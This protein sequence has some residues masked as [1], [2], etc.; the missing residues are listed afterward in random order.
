MK[1][2]YRIYDYVTDENIGL[3]LITLIVVVIPC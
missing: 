3:E 2:G 1:N